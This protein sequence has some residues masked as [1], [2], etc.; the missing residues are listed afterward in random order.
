MSGRGATAIGGNFAAT[1]AGTSAM[2]FTYSAP[3]YLHAAFSLRQIEVHCVGRLSDAIQGSGSAI[4]LDCDLSERADATWAR[5]RHPGARRFARAT[6]VISRTQQVPDPVA[7]AWSA[8]LETPARPLQYASWLAVL[9]LVTG[10][11]NGDPAR[12]R[13]MDYE[14]F[15]A[16]VRRELP[17]WGTK[18]TFTRSPRGYG[19]HWR[20]PAG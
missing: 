3:M 13:K 11:C 20:M 6:D 16:A 15:V 18:K 8:T 7:C 1:H 10:R 12:L 9:G 5:F 2:T 19:R 17:N 4:R 14:K